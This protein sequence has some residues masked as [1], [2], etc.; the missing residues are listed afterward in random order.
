LKTKILLQEATAAA[1]ERLS[2]SSLSNVE[3]ST[4]SEHAAIAHMVK[5]P[6]RDYLLTSENCNIFNSPQHA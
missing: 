2:V 3:S 4:A 5:I 6:K 1:D